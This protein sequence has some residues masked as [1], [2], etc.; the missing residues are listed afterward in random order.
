MARV[1]R[2]RGVMD[3]VDHHHSARRRFDD[4][5]MSRSARVSRAAQNGVICALDE[6]LE[7]TLRGRVA[8]RVIRLIVASRVDQIVNVVLFRS[9]LL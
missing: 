4:R 8:D 5:T 1:N 9:Y 3:V 7:R 2:R 6:S